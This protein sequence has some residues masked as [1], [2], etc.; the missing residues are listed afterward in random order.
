MAPADIARAPSASPGTY[1]LKPGRIVRVACISVLLA[2]VTT[3]AFATTKSVIHSDVFPVISETFVTKPGSYVAEFCLGFSAWVMFANI[4]VVWSY[5]DAFA[6]SKGDAWR[7]HARRSAYV[8]YFGSVCI[9]LTAAINIW[10]SFAAHIFTAFSFMFALTIWIACVF[11]QLRAHPGAVSAFSYR[12]KCC[13]LVGTIIGVLTF[14]GLSSATKRE[15]TYSFIGL[16]E[17]I[18]V[19]SIILFSY[20]ISWDFDAKDVTVVVRFPE[21]LDVL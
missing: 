3:Y 13:A 6:S 4:W 9:A 7:R 8:G 5:L 2:I 18:A 21:M 11:F 10:E 20:T 12:A 15:D 19:M 16:G 17:W 1:A 14:T